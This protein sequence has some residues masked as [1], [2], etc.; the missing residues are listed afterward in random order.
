MKLIA[1][2]KPVKIRILV[3]GVEHRSL[4]SLKEN[5]IWEDVETLLDGRLA[6]WLECIGHKTKAQELDEYREH[7][8]FIDIYNVLFSNEGTPLSF[9][10]ILGFYSPGSNCWSN[11]L[12]QYLKSTTYLSEIYR[13][14]KGNADIL[15]S[16]KD[17][18][19]DTIKRV[20]NLQNI[21]AYSSD[22]LK[23]TCSVLTDSYKNRDC[24]LQ[25]K[26]IYDVLTSRKNE[27][28]ADDMISFFT[29]RRKKND[30]FVNVMKSE[31]IINRIKKSWND[32]QIIITLGTGFSDSERTIV[33]FSNQCMDL[34]KQYNLSRFFYND[35]FRNEK[36]SN[37]VSSD[38][39]DVL[40]YEKIFV[41]AL[42][43]DSRRNFYL[44]KILEYKPVSGFKY[45]FYGQERDVLKRVKYFMN[46][47]SE[48]R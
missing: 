19:I 9:D 48:Y 26:S 39:N 35:L 29:C 14:C 37:L 4:Q 17:H 47:M 2:A 23:W 38:I 18:V 11:L 7:Y 30:D 24:Y 27:T 22:A 5:F 16:R 34:V 21:S 12:A 1:K 33:D 13:I 25:A 41:A 44:D 6:N 42:I 20:L 45:S 8:N 28:L 32:M 46:H 3:G 36:I 40:Y 31:S 15:S 43:D 10:D